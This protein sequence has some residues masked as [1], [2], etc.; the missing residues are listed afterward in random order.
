MH[1][2][3]VLCRSPRIHGTSCEA[4]KVMGRGNVG[5][6]S[7]DAQA[8]E[9]WAGGTH[10]TRRGYTTGPKGSNWRGGGGHWA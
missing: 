2:F 3:W 8:N 6:Q 7:Q 5:T 4:R 10:E 1:R 9:E